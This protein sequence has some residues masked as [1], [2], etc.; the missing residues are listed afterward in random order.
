VVLVA[1]AFCRLNKL[2][3]PYAITNVAAAAAATASAS[4]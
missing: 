4:P 3:Y 2:H 1:K